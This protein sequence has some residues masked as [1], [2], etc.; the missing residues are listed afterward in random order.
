M[1]ARQAEQAG[2]QALRAELGEELKRLHAKRDE[3]AAQLRG[4]RMELT[5]ASPPQAPRPPHITA[6]LG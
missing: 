6:G 1:A 4:L 5:E 2:L 3:D